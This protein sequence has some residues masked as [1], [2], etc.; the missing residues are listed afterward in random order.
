MKTRLDGEEGGGNAAQQSG[1]QGQ[2]NGNQHQQSWDQWQWEGQWSRWNGEWWQWQPRTW[3]SSFWGAS[4][5]SAVESNGQTLVEQPAASSAAAAVVEHHAWQWSAEDWRSDGKWWQT[6]GDYSDPPPWP[7]WQFFRQWKKSLVRWEKNTDVP[8]WR[9]A[10]KILKSFDYELQSKMDHLDKKLLSAPGYLDRILEVLNT[11]AG[12]RDS[13]ERRRMVRAALYEGTRRSDESLA[14]YALRREAQFQSADQYLQLPED[15]KGFM[16]EEQAGLT[17]QGLQN[18]RVL[19]AG[20]PNYRSVCKAL[21]L[22]DVEEESLFRS[23]PKGNYF[24]NDEDSLDD[25]SAPDDDDPDLVLYA[26]DEQDLNEYEA[27]SFLT[28]WQGKKRTWSENKLLKQAKKKDRLHFDKPESRPTRPHNR[29]KL[30]IQELKRVSRC[31]NCLERG[32]WHEEC[33]NAYKPRDPG[34]KL[35]PDRKK[36]NLAAFSYLGSTS[37][38]SNMAS[39]H[40]SGGEN[41]VGDGVDGFESFVA[42][43]AGHA[44]V[45]PGAS[46]DLIGKPAFDRLVKRLAEVGLRPVKI[47]EAP[48]TASGI[49]GRGEALFVALTPC[50]LGEKPGVIKLTVLKDDIP[51]LLSIGLLEH[52]KSIIDTGNNT[53]EFKAFNSVAP[54]VRLESGHRVLD[55]ASW[56]GGSF[57]IPDQV[58]KDFNLSPTAFQLGDSEDPA[59]YMDASVC[60]NEDSVPKDSPLNQFFSRVLRNYLGDDS[61]GDQL[62]C[63]IRVDVFPNSLFDPSVQN[64][65]ACWKSSWWLKGDQGILLEDQIFYSRETQVGCKK[66]LLEPDGILI[67]V[68]VDTQ[69]LMQ[70]NYASSVLAHGRNSV[71]H[72]TSRC[73][74]LVTDVCDAKRETDQEHGRVGVEHE[75]KPDGVERCVKSFPCSV[76]QA[77][78]HLPGSIEAN[79]LDQSSKSLVD[80]SLGEVSHEGKL[81]SDFTLREA[82]VGATLRPCSEPL[83]WPGSSTS[84]PLPQGRQHSDAGGIAGISEVECEGGNGMHPP[85]RASDSRCQSIRSVDQMLGLQEEAELHGLSSSGQSTHQQEQ[86]EWRS[87]DVCTSR[88]GAPQDEERLWREQLILGAHDDGAAGGSTSSEPILG[89][90][91]HHCVGS[92]CHGSTASSTSHGI[93]ESDLTACPVSRTDSPS[94]V[95]AADYAATCARAGGCADEPEPRFG[96][97]T[98]A[99]MSAASF[100][101]HFDVSLERTL[102]NPDRWLV[103]PL[104]PKLLGHFVVSQGQSFFFQ[105]QLDSGDCYLCWDA[106][107]FAVGLM[108]DDLF[109][110]REF[111]D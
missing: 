47:N 89:A 81:A 15:L 56:K 83:V 23:N 32:H 48:T 41:S 84:A 52:A 90:G 98:A 62:G 34:T 38:S 19:T 10:E 101:G 35:G 110:D 111:Y 69:S 24:M 12:E 63:K 64:S 18:L 106:G 67:S 5:A 25:D 2:G 77:D 86:E 20:D 37:S 109:D 57:E 82:P 13:S 50:F 78:H 28:E 53:I 85:S 71:V 30:S 68:F 108:E 3:N 22:L 9:R 102:S 79:L 17:K 49:G 97:G 70:P 1:V 29:R 95:A 44:I 65:A 40:L 100:A 94:D 60:C 36:N 93:F 14:Q 99:V 103:A 6:K 66:F 26:I 96:M 43:P 59:A 33:K 80:S 91:H 88:E 74:Q 75:S 61:F 76:D 27:L 31:G 45:D 54:M 55:V 39:Y 107:V 42:V 7:G 8:T 105:F 58:L 21:K 46:Q 92:N 87:G 72:L 51:Q 104:S 4:N 16:M 73:Q 11:L